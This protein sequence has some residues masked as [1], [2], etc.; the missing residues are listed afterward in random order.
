M[1]KVDWRAIEAVLAGTGSVVAGWVF[2][3][4]KNGEIRPGSD[5]DVAVPGE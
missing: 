3:S 1:S 4:A 2:G 5:L